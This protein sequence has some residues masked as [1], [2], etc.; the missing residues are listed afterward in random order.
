M[1]VFGHFTAGGTG[2]ASIG[3]ASVLAHKEL[4]K[5]QSQRQ[6][7]MPFAPQKKLGMAYAVLFYRIAQMVDG[8]LLT[9]DVGK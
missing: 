4:G 7:P 2:S 9:N 1:L 3:F 6:R 5:S 8:I